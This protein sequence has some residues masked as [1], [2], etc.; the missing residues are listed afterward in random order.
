MKPRNH[1]MTWYERH[2]RDLPWR[3]TRDPYAIW[4][5]EIML[6]QTRVETALPYYQEF[7][8]RFPTVEDLA[9]AEIEEVLG[10]WSGLGY[11]RRA[12]MLHGAARQISARGGRLPDNLDE[13]RQMPGVGSY[14]AAAIGSIAFGIAEPAIDG[15]VERVI[16]RYLGI[17]SDPKKG[18]GRRRV[19]AGAREMI[20]ERRPGDSNQALME[21]G[22]TLCRPR[23]P[24]CEDCPLCAGC[25]AR[26][27]GDPES[28][29]VSGP[30]PRTIRVRRRVAVV[31]NGQR[32]LLFRRPESS[33]QLAGM[34]ELPWVESVDGVP[35]QAQFEDRYPGEWKLGDSVGVVRHAI[36]QR[37]FEIE[38]LSARL[39]TAEVVADGPEAGWFDTAEIAALPV[40]SMVRKVLQVAARSGALAGGE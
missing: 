32:V 4:I 20:D 13:L 40:S 14:T 2:R 37:S 24:Q 38:V 22:A 26:I 11:Y 25:Q 7:L 21:L 9:R 8:N 16:S 27:T 36:T 5:S 12:R 15:N 29:P 1:L 39:A 33:G 19:L 34:W 3:R 30:R 28:L 23:R 10:A 35:R 17:D 31:Q 6:Q 18:E